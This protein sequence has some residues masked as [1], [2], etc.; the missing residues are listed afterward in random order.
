M[1]DATLPGAWSAIE[2]SFATHLLKGLCKA[3]SCEGLVIW[4]ILWMDMFHVRSQR[5]R[6]RSLKSRVWL[7]FRLTLT[8]EKSLR[9]FPITGLQPSSVYI[10][11]SSVTSS[12]SFVVITSLIVVHSHTQASVINHDLNPLFVCN[13]TYMYIIMCVQYDSHLLFIG[14]A[15]PPMTRP[16]ADTYTYSDVSVRLPLA[17]NNTCIVV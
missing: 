9:S 17:N 14:V 6:L 5:N 13:Y 10:H 7:Q 15:I 4:S 2:V 1:Q 16:N 3:L 12:A 8:V 11:S